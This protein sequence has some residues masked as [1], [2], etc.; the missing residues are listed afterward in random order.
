MVDGRFTPTPVGTIGQRARSHRP[1]AV[2]PHARGD[3]SIAGAQDL[4]KH[5]SPPRPWGQWWAAVAGCHPARFTPTPVGT[6]LLGKVKKLCYAVHPHARGDNQA[7]DGGIALLGGSPPRPWGQFA[8]APGHQRWLRF[9]PTPVGTMRAVD[10]APAP[11]AVHPHAR[12]DNAHRCGSVAVARGSPP[13][14]WGQS[15]RPRPLLCRLRFTP[16][17]VGTIG[18]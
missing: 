1:P 9:T 12:G 7:G 18:G 8:Y 3:N 2:H 13:R 11:R 5:G 17:P 15:L 4:I 10:P 16:T 14:P 6:M